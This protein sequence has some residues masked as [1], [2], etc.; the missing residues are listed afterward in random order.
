MSAG[1]VCSRRPASVPSCCL[2]A[3]RL[4]RHICSD[5]TLPPQTTR[6]SL[7]CESFRQGARS[8][9][10]HGGEG[11]VTAA[12]LDLPYRG[13]QALSPAASAS[14]SSINMFSICSSTHGRASQKSAQSRNYVLSTTLRRAMPWHAS[15]S[16]S[17]CRFALPRGCR[18]RQRRA[19]SEPQKIRP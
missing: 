8:R 11:V 14:T 15:P 2:C 6:G 5:T 10:K 16:I 3:N 9:Q 4:L 7:R 1:L 18:A 12:R 17:A 13:S 19:R